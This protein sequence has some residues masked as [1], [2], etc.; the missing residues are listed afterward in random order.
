MKPLIL[1][2]LLELS[3]FRAT[4]GAAAF[5]SPFCNPPSSQRLST[6]RCDEQHQHTPISVSETTRREALQLISSIPILASAAATAPIAPTNANAL[7]SAVLAIPPQTRETSWPLGKVAFSLLPLAGSYSR[8]A[9]GEFGIVLF[10]CEHTSCV[11]R[12]SFVRTVSFV[13]MIWP[14]AFIPMSN[15]YI[16]LSHIC[17]QKQLNNFLYDNTVK[18]TI[19]DDGVNGMWTFD[20]LQGVVNVN[21]P[22]RMTVVKVCM[23]IHRASDEISCTYI[24]HTDSHLFRPIK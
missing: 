24:T 20:Q 21:V 7:E 16:C 23:F 1:L 12:H 13:Q 18:E 6:H 14:L 19:V 9:T 17:I 11:Q 2:W 22:V 5:I 3:S 10:K 15:S 4:Q 8:R